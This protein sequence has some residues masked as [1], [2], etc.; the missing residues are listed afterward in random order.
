MKTNAYTYV[1]Y[2]HEQLADSASDKTVIDHI[3]ATSRDAAVDAVLQQYEA[4]DPE[5]I[6]LFEGVHHNF[7]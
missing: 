4:D 5:V 6:C 1:V 2:L 3:R 7:R